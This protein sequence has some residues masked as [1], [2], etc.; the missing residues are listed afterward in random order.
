MASKWKGA[1]DNGRKYNKAWESKFIWVT[2]ALDGSAD[3]FCKLCHATVK[4]KLCNLTKHEKT[5][6]HAQHVKISNTTKPIQVIRVPKLADEV[7][8]AE[9]ELA[10]TM[11]CHSAIMTMDHLGEV[12]VRN[13]K[14]SK[15]EKL[16]MHRKKCTQILTNVVSPAMKEELIADV[17]GKRFSLIVDE[18]TDVSAAKELCVIVRYF[19]QVEKKI[20]TAFVDLIP[21]VHTSADDL[22][23]A[24]KDCL[25]DINLD[26]AN[27]VG[28]ASD[29]ASVMVG[30]HDSVW[31]RIA[32]VSPHCIKM[33]CICH[34]L[35]LCV[36]HAFEKL[37]SSLGFL[38]A[39]IPKWFSKSSVRREAYKELYEV[40]SPDECQKLRSRSIQQQGG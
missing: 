2:K 31:T 30:Q 22:F 38:L 35:S 11:A 16:K 6:K 9:I 40:M 15:L 8:N 20:L 3:A 7:K 39:E 26:L 34:S 19:S 37:P 32:S 1:Y 23:N 17:Q 5:V 24:I 28:Y 13:A 18:S 36:M 4:P 27:C 33:T 12:I 10:V 25:N 21:V 14:G 29:G